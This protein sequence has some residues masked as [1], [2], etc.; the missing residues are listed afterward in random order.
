M[1]VNKKHSVLLLLFAL[2]ILLVCSPLIYEQYLSL[3]V[4]GKTI[5]HISL[6]SEKYFVRDGK[7]LAENQDHEASYG[8]RLQI[9]RM[10]NT[11]QSLVS[12][13]LLTDGNLHSDTNEKYLDELETAQAELLKASG[14]DIQVVPVGFLKG[15]LSLSQ[16]RKALD[17]GISAGSLAKY[18]DQVQEVVGQY[19]QS[20]TDLLKKQ[21]SLGSE[22]S[23]SNIFTSTNTS[24]V[25]NDLKLLI[26]NAKSLESE[27]E[28][29]RLILSGVVP[30]LDFDKKVTQVENIDT[31][32]LGPELDKADLPS[33]STV[34]RISS[35]QFVTKTGCFDGEN[36][37]KAFLLYSYFHS[38]RQA[39]LPKL[40]NTNIF[41]KVSA[42]KVFTLQRDRGLLW[43][44]LREGNN[45][46][47][48][49]NSYQV[50]ILNTYTYL[51]R[52]DQPVLASIYREI[53]HKKLSKAEKGSFESAINAEARFYSNDSIYY[54]D[55]VRLSN[56]YQY[57]ATT[58][59][60]N[61]NNS[62]FTRILNE[63]SRHID[64]RES[65]LEM[66][67]A[68]VFNLDSM[69]KYADKEK[70]ATPTSLKYLYFTRVDYSIS[71]FTFSPLVWRHK[72]SPTYQLPTAKNEHY[73]YYDDLVKVLGVV[74]VREIES[75]SRT[76][77]MEYLG[78]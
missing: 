9:L 15:L 76:D 40:A 49:D 58:L 72:S 31:H 68:T 67:F 17:T 30:Y 10:A 7:V 26:D 64:N 6:G 47:C 70:L 56:N 4:R 23:T 38:S 57:V 62:D 66:L 33:G 19:R 37:E 22:F 29:R 35:K 24:I 36:S 12:D 51:K 65:G 69:L 25:K 13:P 11:Y 39:L 75:I 14:Q 18:L 2:G 34:T 77:E 1:K 46:R 60:G 21:E 74:K 59:Q 41:Q 32:M 45:Y 52:F 42:D 48:M 28:H 50:D 73:K 54:D 63:R 16:S 78:L 3:G 43:S 61:G 44:Q 8:V 55:L 27:I 53:D 20:A 71:Y 5:E